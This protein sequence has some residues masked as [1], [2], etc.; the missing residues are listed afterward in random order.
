MVGKGMPRPPEKLYHKALSIAEEQEASCGNCA[1]PRASP[2]YATS[3][4]R[5]PDA[6]RERRSRGR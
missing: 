1:R 5:Y 2:G 6:P 3:K 4:G